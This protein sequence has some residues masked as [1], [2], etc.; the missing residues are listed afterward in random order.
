[1]NNRQRRILWFL[2]LAEEPMTS[3]QLG[4]KLGVSSRTIKSDMTFVAEELKANGAQLISRRNCGYSIQVTDAEKFQTMYT[5]ISI[6]VSSFSPVNEEDRLL[7][8]ARKLVGSRRGVL[9]DELEEELYLTRSSLRAPLHEAIRFCESFHL[10]TTSSVGHG[11]RVV[12]EEHLIRMA[13]TELFELHFHKAEL[14]QVDE[15]YAQ[16]VGCEYQER[17][18]I[19]HAFLKVL[20]ESSFAMRDSVTQRIAMYLIIARNRRRAGLRIALPAA[21]IA[22]VKSLPIYAVASEIYRVLQSNFTDYG[23]DTAET[24]FLA[25]YMLTNLD[26]DIHRDPEETAPVI[27]PL[28]HTTARAMLESVRRETGTDLAAMP[29]AVEMLEQ[30]VL[31]ILLGA[32][33]GLDGHQC[34]DYSYENAYMHMPVEMHYARLL[35]EEMHRRTA[36]L[37]SDTDLSVLSCYVAALLREAEYPTNPLRLLVTNSIGVDFARVTTIGLRQMFP[38]LIKSIRQVELY[39]IRGIDPASYDAVLVGHF[40]DSQ[41]KLFGYNYDAPA[42]TLLLTEQ[43]RDFMRVH[44]RIL[45]GAYR[46]EELIPAESEIEIQKD[47]LYYDPGQAFQFL[48]GRYAKDAEHGERLLERLISRDQ[49]F[50]M[51]QNGCAM[52]LA[53]HTMCRKQVFALYRLK[54]Q[55]QWDKHKINWI[56]FVSMDTTQMHRVKAMGAALDGLTKYPERYEQLAQNPRQTLLKLLRES[57]QFQ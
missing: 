36:C 57:V 54:K 15:E 23:M 38:K 56:L 47:F 14:D 3:A 8:I 40:K 52:V 37:V 50:S 44:N 6:K 34:F 39:E 55:G 20:R 22:E 17:Q 30:V 1:M 27:A 13:L 49:A 48:C 35:G 32:R 46:F 25:M 43:G 33:Y 7:Y 31:P 41:D 29:D 9:V 21:W 10:Q 53:E 12:G 51:A 19:R 26:P 42:A 11:L 16:W 28:V 45:I 5:L 24:C 18:D 2:A 4:Q